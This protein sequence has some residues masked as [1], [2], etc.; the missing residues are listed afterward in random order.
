[1]FKIINEKTAVLPYHDFGC[2]YTV[3]SMRMHICNMCKYLQLE[4]YILC[5]LLCLLLLVV[6]LLEVAGCSTCYVMLHLP[7]AYVYTQQVT[8]MFIHNK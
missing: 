8:I 1:V 6:Y 7:L 5:V 4:F 3:P 2:Y